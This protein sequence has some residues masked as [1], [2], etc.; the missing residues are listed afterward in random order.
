MDQ[1]EYDLRSI[2]THVGFTGGF[3]LHTLSTS[4]HPHA[5]GVYGKLGNGGPLVGRSIPTHVGFTEAGA[6][7]ARDAIRSIPTHVGFTAVGFLS[8]KNQFGPSPRTWG[9]LLPPPHKFPACR[10]IPTHVGFTRQKALMENQI[11]GPSPRTW[12]LR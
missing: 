10:S 1:G 6:E 4:V 5:R 8:V 11:T 12:G 2:P 3:S 9:L 7:A